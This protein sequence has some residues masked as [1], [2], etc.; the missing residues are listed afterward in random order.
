MQ[1]RVSILAAVLFIGWMLSG[2]AGAVNP[3]PAYCQNGTN[4]P[5][6]FLKVTLTQGLTTPGNGFTAYPLGTTGTRDSIP[7]VH[8]M[9]NSVTGSYNSASHTGIWSNFITNYN[10]TRAGAAA[11]RNT[12]L[13]TS[14]GGNAQTG[15]FTNFDSTMQLTANTA[16]TGQSFYVSANISAEANAVAGGTGGSPLGSVTGANITAALDANATNFRGLAG[17][18]I[19]LRANSGS[20]YEFQTGLSVVLLSTNA[21]VPSLEA[22]GFLVSDQANGGGT[23]TLNSVITIGGY[24]GFNPL[25]SSATII[26]Y[27]PHSGSGSY[28]Q[29][30]ITDGIDLHLIAFTGKA[31]RGAN[32]TF[33]VDGSGNVVAASYTA[34]ASAG[35]SCGAGTV[36]LTTEIVTNGIVT[37][38]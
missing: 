34:G 38:C 31:F 24:N 23:N 10:V 19:D 7:L 22:E 21:A 2:D 30:T 1:A 27:Y 18:E 11:V 32:D 5:C 35:V 20:S 9:I 14:V 37:H 16:D 17:A 6:S 29:A 26:T 25:S 15:G 33:T 28:P 13:F 4:N 36:N 8:S 12:Y 3:R